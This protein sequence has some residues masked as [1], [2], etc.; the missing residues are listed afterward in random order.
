MTQID[1]NWFDRN[2]GTLRGRPLFVGSGKQELVLAGVS[3]STNLLGS[4]RSTDQ[5]DE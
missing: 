1:R 2:G 5:E 4:P 3:A